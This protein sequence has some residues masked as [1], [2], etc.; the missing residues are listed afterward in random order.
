MPCALGEAMGSVKVLSFYA[1]FPLLSDC[2]Y[3]IALTKAR[4]KHIKKNFGF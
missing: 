2:E 3:E 4:I 1:V